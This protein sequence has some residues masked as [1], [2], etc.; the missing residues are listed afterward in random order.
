[1]IKELHL[2]NFKSYGF[3]KIEF[4][5]F[6]CICGTNGSGKSNI[7]DGLA[8]GLAVGAQ[9][10][11]CSSIKELLREGEDSGY[12]KIV[13]KIG[14]E[15]TVFQRNLN[16]QG[17]CEYKIDGKTLSYGSYVDR[18]NQYNVLVKVRN[19]VVFQGDIE[20]LAAQSSKDLTRLIENISGSYELKTEY[21]QLKQ[22]YEKANDISLTNFSKKKGINAE[23]KS[24]L[25]QKQQADQWGKLHADKKTLVKTLSLWKLWHI[26]SDLIK[27]DESIEVIE[28]EESELIAM[29]DSSDEA[30]K[31]I[32][33]K[34]KNARQQLEVRSN[35]LDKLQKSLND[36]LGEKRASSDR[37]SQ[38]IE[39]EKDLVSKKESI[40]HKRE[41]RQNFLRDINSR[42]KE[43]QMEIDE[44]RALLPKEVKKNAKVMSLY[45]NLKQ[46]YL[47]QCGD[48]VQKL[49]SMNIK[50]EQ[51]E[52]NAFQCKI[53]SE[54]LENKLEETGANLRESEDRLISLDSQKKDLRN[55]LSDK[56]LA[57]SQ[58][59]SKVSDV[60]EQKE[61]LKSK[62]ASTLSDIQQCQS[63]EETKNREKNLL[64]IVSTL[65]GLY[66]GVHGRIVDVCTPKD[67]S[68][69]GVLSL[70]LG[71]YSDAVIVESE[72][73]AL[74]CITFMKKQ[75]YFPLTFLPI[76]RLD[77]KTNFQ[78]YRNSPFKELGAV[79]LIDCLEF[80]ERFQKAVEYSCGSILIVD[81]LK[82]AKKIAFE[83]NE[84]E[85]LVTLTGEIIYKNG[86]MSGGSLNEKSKFTKSQ[87]E[88]LQAEKSKILKAIQSL[89][90]K[91][92][93]LHLKELDDEIE[94]INVQL[95]R[96]NKAI[97]KANEDQKE[98]QKLISSYKND[99]ESQDNT[100]EDF[101]QQVGLRKE[102]YQDSLSKLREFEKK[103]YKP[104]LDLT[105]CKSIQEYEECEVAISNNKL[106]EF[107]NKEKELI[108]IHKEKD[109]VIQKIELDGKKLIL[110]EKS[111][112]DSIQTRS[113][114]SIELK[115]LTKLCDSIKKKLDDLYS[116]YVAELK[117]SVANYD[118][119]M[120]L[121]LENSKKCAK[122]LSKKKDEIR[123]L[124]NNKARLFDR[125]ASEVR[126]CKIKDVDVELVDQD[127]KE[128]VNTQ[129]I[130]GEV[131]IDNDNTL[132]E[133]TKQLGQIQIDYEV[134]EIKYREN[135][136]AEIEI[137]LENDIKKIEAEM[138]TLGNFHHVQ[139][140]LQEVESKLKLSE[141]DFNRSKK[142]ARSTKQDFME[143]KKSRVGKFMEA[144][145]VM[146]DNI[147][148]IYKQLTAS[149]SLE[150]GGTAYLTLDDNEE[151]YDSLVHYHT[152]PPAKRFREMENLSG[153]ERTLVIFFNLGCT[154]F[155][156]H[157]SKVSK[158]SVYNLR[159][160]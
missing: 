156:I 145:S 81:S 23:L 90:D 82:N 56:T 55:S 155:D 67:D 121:H 159:R 7:L 137:E 51:F 57:M 139:E 58:L 124:L 73:V 78:K 22:E 132:T 102:L 128:A 77:R 38:L 43:L 120:Q 109:L 95:D 151:P 76:D 12:V 36:E 10:L 34:L 136:G 106:I 61:K 48:D 129:M 49:E 29:K 96:N 86:S 52:R 74:D 99:L 144:F 40:L 46:K 105:R 134:L 148:H 33:A 42:Q 60:L 94:T 11:R 126:M 15:E 39:K 119:E 154:G 157:N 103:H 4:K 2:T 25:E 114:I 59:K 110:I 85:K 79:L 14:E 37:F 97:L 1:M 125:K 118:D 138:E 26:D 5:T 30:A 83:L 65:K 80:N 66:Q 62:L 41:M 160:S 101:M 146:S 93:E 153:G 147:D 32:E 123:K 115:H 21:D 16:I 142:D 72:S 92:D 87:I 3:A 28:N 143:V 117:K 24:V 54:N 158:K 53:K 50:I 141:K 107:E 113:E 111:L 20:Q 100:Y 140:K 88:K 108:E 47:L 127:M 70:A 133:E 8:F 45:D 68:I 6:A 27:L 19:F 89:A 71:R 149:R 130:V 135:S 75:R 122:L 84:R 98:F 91:K 64:N 13:M 150:S 31:E 69:H 131:N 152:M 63:M 17:H 9:Q 44:K 116:K 112:Q 104:L 18:L 35:D